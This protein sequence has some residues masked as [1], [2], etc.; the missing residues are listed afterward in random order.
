MRKVTVFFCLLAVLFPA[1]VSAKNQVQTEHYVVVFDEGNE[2]YAQQVIMV[3]EEVWSSLATSYNLVNDYKKIYIYILDPG[4]FANGYAIPQKNCVTIYT[5]NLNA[6]IRGTSNWIRNVVTHELSHVF[7]MKAAA[8]NMLVDNFSIRYWT[9]F[10]N[11]DWVAV[12]QYRNFLAPMWWVEGVAQYEAYRHHND[13]WDTHR[14]MFLRMAVL[15]NDLLNYVEMGTYGNRNGFYEEMVY[16]QGY[17]MVRFIDSLHGAD[18]VHKSALT[19]SYFNFNGSLK[20][21][22]GKTGQALYAQWKEALG[23]QYGAVAAAVKKEPREGALVY[24]GGFWDHFPSLSPD[25]K[26]LALVSN[27]GYDVRYSHLFVMDLASK[28]TRR[29]LKERNTV[30]SRVQWFPDGERLLYARWSERAAYLDLYICG[31]S[32]HDEQA[33]TWHG[34][35][36]DPAIAPDGKTVVYVENRGGIQNLVLI[37]ADGNNKRQLTNFADHTQLYSPSWTPDGKNLVVGIFRD[38]DRDIAMVSAG[39]APLDKV[40][41][42]TDTAFFPESLNFQD[43]FSFRLLVHTT[44][45]ERDPCV[46]ADGKTLYFSSDRTGIFNIYRMDLAAAMARDTMA[47]PVHDTAAAAV[48]DTLAA[49]DTAMVQDTSAPPETLVAQD[50]TRSPLDVEVEQVTN[51]LGGAFHPC[52]DRDN[53]VLYYTGFHAANYSVYS[54]PAKGFRT[55]TLSNEPRE[56]VERKREPFVFSSG[57]DDGKNPLKPY[58]YPMSPYKPVYTLWDVSP[59]V[60]ISPAYI[61]DSIGDMLIRGGM[62]FLLGELSGIANLQGYVFGGQSTQNRPGLSWGGGLASNVRL[63]GISGT[64]YDFQPWANLVADRQVFRSNDKLEPE[65]VSVNREPYASLLIPS[66]QEDTLLAQYVDFVDGSF[67]GSQ[68]FD[69]GGIVGGVQFDRYHSLSADLFYQNIYFDGDVLNARLGSTLRVYALPTGGWTTNAQD[70]TDTLLNDADTTFLDSVIIFNT[71]TDSLAATYLNYYD[72]FSVYKDFQAGLSYFYENIR[73]AQVMVSRADLFAARCALASSIL[74][75]GATFPGSDTIIEPD[76]KAD[77]FLLINKNADGKPIA[78]IEPLL[79]RE[80]FARFELNALERFPLG[81]R[82]HLATFNA[83]FGT[84]DRRLPEQGTTYPLQYRAGWFMRAYPYSFDPI[85]TATTTDSIAVADIFGQMQFLHYTAD[86]K[87][88][89][90]KDLLWGN[91]IMYLNAEY[92]FEVARGITLKPLGLLVQGL[93]ATVFA[94]AA[95]L[96]N[97]DILDFSLTELLGMGNGFSNPGESFIKDAG[98]RIDLPFVLFENWNAFITFTWARRLSLDDAILS[99]DAADNIR[100]LDKDRFSFN[101]LLTN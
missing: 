9:R 53:G 37:G 70:I 36:M 67:R 68:T 79:M 80:N 59:F 77:P 43:D 46:S 39:A 82:R 50:T 62:Q 4:D 98:L 57:A 71:F 60:S 38:K 5:T 78:F 8:K 41:K 100:H 26:Q 22:T 90:R 58:Q 6:G 72:R 83:F 88:M 35:S 17:S 54:I 24:D 33:L 2:F 19:K 20:K 96:W 97:S 94:E 44:A 64:N 7:S 89:I 1:L 63:P 10:Q 49:Q 87:D 95:G 65:P 23:R 91:R 76:N 73:P 32:G 15:E 25:G 86:D 99:I 81:S 56:Y 69:D 75:I 14:D 66:T 101:F 93:Y 3:A 55:V 16:N 61:T 52:V 18:A 84:L 29:L 13:F 48:P 34:R 11:P 28:K 45:D 74:T 27:K 21:A 42:L 92:T 47:A 40:R 51:V 31:P 12:G 30:N 85:D